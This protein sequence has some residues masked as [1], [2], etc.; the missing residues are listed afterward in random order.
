M[1]LPL[2][3]RSLAADAFERRSIDRLLAAVSALLPEIY[4]DTEACRQAKME[5][6]TV[7]DLEGANSLECKRAAL[8]F[9]LA[10]EKELGLHLAQTAEAEDDQRLVEDLQRR[11]L[12]FVFP[13][14]LRNLCQTP[15][16]MLT[17][18][19]VLSEMWAGDPLGNYGPAGA[20][21][22]QSSEAVL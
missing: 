3:Q 6:D 20:A 4:G 5:L 19:C 22:H 11:G 18:S 21:Y 8:L 13:R 10:R 14:F 12:P 1:G 17:L 7:V 16:S 2:S 15:D 9:A